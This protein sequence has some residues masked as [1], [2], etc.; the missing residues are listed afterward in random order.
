MPNLT[1]PDYWQDRAKRIILAGEKSADEITTDLKSVYT[2]YYNKIIKEIESFYGRYAS[3]QGV[4]ISTAMRNL[5]RSELKSY[6]EQVQQYLDAIESSRYSFDPAYRSKLNRELSIKA[7]VSRL[8]AL[9]SEVQ[10]Q[11]ENLYAREQDAFKVGLSAA[12]E[13]S[14]YRSTF[15]LQQGIGYGSAFTRPSNSMIE[16][17]VRTKWLGANY[18]DRIWIDKDRLTLNLER[19]IPQGIA[20][21]NNPR[22]IGREISKQ[23]DVR[24]SYGERLA[25]T[26]F[27]RIANDASMDSYKAVGVAQYKILATLDSRTSSIC[28]E[29]DGKI[30]Y[31]GEEEVGTNF[32]PF[33]PNCRTTTIPYFEPDEIDAMFDEA[34]R[35]AKDPSGEKYLVSADMKYSEWAKDRGI[36]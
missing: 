21:G 1:N 24:K 17:A 11:I 3:E 34:K 13:D 16:K 8:E 29:F 36:K 30:F 5:S 31:V 28:I 12:Y 35:I 10:W 20:L 32:P 26:E 25:R 22:I 23:M 19:I 27:N 15:N 7:A 18:S 33:H 6:Y 9:K 2:E 14:Y 4:S